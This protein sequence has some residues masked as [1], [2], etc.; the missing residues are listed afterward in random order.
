MKPLGNRKYLYS[1]LALTVFSILGFMFY[2]STSAA[3]NSVDDE[4]VRLP[5]S[6]LR[7]EKRKFYS[8]SEKLPGQ[9]SAF[10]EADQGFDR[11]GI[12]AKIFVDEGSKVKKGQV[13]A[14]LDTRS[15]IARLAN[16]KA[17]LHVAEANFSEAKA[18][19][20]MTVNKYN[21]SKQL[22]SKG[23]I[24]KEKFEAEEFSL[25]SAEAGI[26]A[27]KAGILQAK[28]GLDMVTADLNLVTLRAP[29]AGLITKRFVDEGASLGGA[30][31]A[32]HI[33]EDQKLVIHVG[34]PYGLA[35]T[36]KT[37]QLYNFKG[38]IG[39]VSAK[40]RS[41]VNIIDQATQTVMA[42]FDV[43]N[44]DMAA[45][46]EIAYLTLDHKIEA[47]GFWVPV[48]ALAESRRGLWSLYA[49]VKDSNGDYRTSRREVQILYTGQDRVFVRGTL[50][51][52]EKIVK[53]GT[54]RLVPEQIISISDKF[55][56]QEQ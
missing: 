6:I 1:L 40:L 17:A 54:Y 21:R 26:M 24:S 25:R 48:S 36:L 11:S 37:G 18:R 34:V 30:K 29:Y 13:L 35:Q 45:A 9:I 27:R 39:T 51:H 46:G 16:A 2:H 5:V 44:T 23:H 22:F 55:M 52:G 28:A 53:T 20:D 43:Q 47:L 31:P 7:L 10:R 56:G 4:L 50:R 19:L 12:V 3:Q 15:I 49:A 33:I 32:V 8:I 42:I 14:Q 41:V 38:Q